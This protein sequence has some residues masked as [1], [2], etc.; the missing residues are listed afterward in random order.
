LTVDGQKGWHRKVLAT[1]IVKIAAIP[2]VMTP[3]HEKI[4]HRQRFRKRKGRAS[5]NETRAVQMRERAEKKT[6]NLTTRVSCF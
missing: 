4:H 2:E 5:E 3:E 1:I 6:M